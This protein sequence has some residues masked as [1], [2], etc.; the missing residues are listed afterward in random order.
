MSLQVNPRL[1]SEIQNRAMSKGVSPEQLLEYL[2]HPFT[3]KPQKPTLTMLLM[4]SWLEEDA[5]DDPEEIREAEESLQEF[6]RN[7]N[8]PRKEANARLLYPEGE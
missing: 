8:Q 2:L 3:Q 4:R 1:E 5:T 7:M 6:K